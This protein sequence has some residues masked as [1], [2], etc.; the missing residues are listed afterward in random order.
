M[1]RIDWNA[2][3]LYYKLFYKNASDRAMVDVKIPDPASSR[4]RI[5]DAGYHELW[6]FQIQAGND[7]GPGY[8]SPIARAYSG[9]GPPAG[10]PEGVTVGT[11]TVRSVELS[12]KPVTVSRGSVDGYRVSLSRG[13]RSF[14]SWSIWSRKCEEIH[15]YL[16]VALNTLLFE[17][18]PKRHR[19]CDPCQGSSDKIRVLQ[20]RNRIYV[21]PITSS[22]A[23]S[24]KFE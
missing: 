6:E 20:T 22:D 24:G 8:V 14:M 21:L 5:Q 15:R 16:L 7:E 23:D 10:K 12:W 9:Q 3:G 4:F 19:T 13:S 18:S 11:V 1:P 17:Q 2:P